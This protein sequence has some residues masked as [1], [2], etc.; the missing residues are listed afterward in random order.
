[1]TKMEYQIGRI[2]KALT[3]LDNRI[4]RLE[5]KAK[6]DASIPWTAS[7]QRRRGVKDPTDDAGAGSH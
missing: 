4:R 3:A 5:A 7:N 1:M 6:S 2:L